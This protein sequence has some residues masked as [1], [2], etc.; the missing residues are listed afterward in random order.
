MKLWKIRQTFGSL[1]YVPSYVVQKS[2]HDV[3]LMVE[4]KLEMILPKFLFQ[5]IYVNKIYGFEE[6]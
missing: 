6:F 1:V 3:K 4:Y 5:Q 2:T